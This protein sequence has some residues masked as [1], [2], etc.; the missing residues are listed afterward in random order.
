[1][2]KGKVCT[3]I[4]DSSSYRNVD[5]VE[6]V[7]KLNLPLIT[8]PHPYKLSWLNDCGEVNVSKLI[9]ILL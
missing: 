9:L 2:V 7:R 4:I 6:I 8:H 1:M 3:L 5:S